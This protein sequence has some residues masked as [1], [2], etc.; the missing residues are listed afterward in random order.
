MRGRIFPYLLQQNSARCKQLRQN[1][2]FDTWLKG[3]TERI[4]SLS[5]ALKGDEVKINK[6]RSSFREL[7][8]NTPRWDMLT[9]KPKSANLPRRRSKQITY[10]LSSSDSEDGLCNASLS[11]GTQKTNS[12][13][14]LGLKKQLSDT[15][16]LL[17]KTFKSGKME[18]DNDIVQSSKCLSDQ[19]N[20]PASI[21]S[22]E[23]RNKTSK[24]DV[25]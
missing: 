10:Y 7:E 3:Q 18:N 6:L 22:L 13:E 8:L 23:K 14:G 11:T 15:I 5:E 2:Y 17:D 4:N 19:A 1:D 25:Q 20:N 24:E 16:L 12:H 9:S 21:E